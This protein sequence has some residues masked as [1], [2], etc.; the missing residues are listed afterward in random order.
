MAV[1]P[2]G[3]RWVRGSG[4]VM[5]TALSAAYGLSLLRCTDWFVASIDSLKLTARLRQ[6]HGCLFLRT[7]D[8]EHAS[9]I[10]FLGPWDRGHSGPIWWWFSYEMRS[11]NS[12][13]VGVPLWAP[14]LSAALPTAYAW[15]RCRR[16]PPGHCP[17]CG[18]D[19]AG[20]AAGV[21]PECGAAISRQPAA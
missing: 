10:P 12:P 3:W 2:R 8:Y 5:C 6:H 19:L 15:Y 16:R 13:E 14:L 1:A 9:P 4:V 21:C 7:V 11:P 20:I 17:K 18:Y